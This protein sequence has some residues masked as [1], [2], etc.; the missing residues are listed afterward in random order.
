MNLY[1][2]YR[3]QTFD[4]FIGNINTIEILSK[5]A[6]NKKQ[7]PHV[8][9]F[10]GPT[11]C[12]KTTMARIL[13][14]ELKCGKLDYH[15]IDSADFRGIDTIRELRR[16]SSFSPL[17]GDCRVW[18]IDEC[19]KLT[20]DAQNALLKLLEDTPKHVYIILCTTDPQKLLATIRGRC[21]QFQMQLLNDMEMMRLLRG[22]VKKENE[23]IEKV[24]Y[25][26]IIE[27]SYGHPRNALQALEK[28]LLTEESGRLDAAKQASFEKSES[29]ELCRLLIN[30]EASWKKIANIL[31]GL[32]EQDPESI[33]RHVLG[34]MTSVLLKNDNKRAALIIFEFIEP[35]Y[36]S[37]FAGL[38]NACYSI[39]N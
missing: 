31:E 12:G 1:L 32:K 6:G 24:I 16:Q 19:H 7:C 14:N 26:Q 22:V 9:L 11:G 13:A 39:I 4:E 2:K 23:S 3:P 5:M 28:V 21:N 27:D 33:R 36:N 17:D 15:E 37:G 38:V 34:Y 10:H 25:E 20:N 30:P 18:T 8:F 29:I 35:F